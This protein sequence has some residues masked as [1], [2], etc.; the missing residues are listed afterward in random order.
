MVAYLPLGADGVYG[1][2]AVI[3]ISGVFSS[4]L[5][6]IT[7]ELLLLRLDPEDVEALS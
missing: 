7:R 1:P 5:R 3:Q 2:P 6:S 4:P